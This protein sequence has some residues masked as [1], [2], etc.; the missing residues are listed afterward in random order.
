MNLAA[1]EEAVSPGAVVD[2]QS[3]P[4]DGRATFGPRH[5]RLRDGRGRAIG[6]GRRLLVPL[7]FVRDAL[8][9]GIEGGGRG[10]RKEE[11]GR[12]NLSSTW[13]NTCN[14]YIILIQY[15]NIIRENL[16]YKSFALK[17]PLGRKAKAR[18]KND[19]NHTQTTNNGSH[20]T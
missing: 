1:A 15:T 3:I 18:E 5:D 19:A 9:L 6:G 7:L 16:S 11:E 20:R 12:K 10:E 13:N 17:V 14:S 8:I 4:E 2:H